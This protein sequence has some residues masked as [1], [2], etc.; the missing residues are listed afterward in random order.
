MTQLSHKAILL[1]ASWVVIG[2]IHL[3]VLTRGLRKP[4]PE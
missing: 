2:V 3:V 1:G 4:P